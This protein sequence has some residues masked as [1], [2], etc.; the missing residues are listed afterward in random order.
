MAGVRDKDL[1]KQRGFP[2]GVDNVSPDQALPRDDDGNS[3]AARKLVN[4]D[5]VDDK[6]RTRPGRVLLEEG[7]WHSP[8]R[9][10]GKRPARAMFAVK[11][12]DLR[13]VEN[14]VATTTIRAGVGTRRISYTEVLGDLWWS[15]G[16]IIRRIRR[17]DLADMPIGPG[18]P[19][20]P[21]AEAYPGGALEAG[22]YAIAATWFDADGRESGAWGSVPVE[23]PAGHS[24]RVFDI[25]AAPETAVLC[26]IYA[27]NTNGDELYAAKEVAAGTTNTL[28]TAHDVREATRALETLWHDPFPPCDTL[29]WWNGR[30]FGVTGKNCLVWSPALRP[31][32]HHPDAYLRQGAEITL[33][34]PLQNAG[35]WFADHKNTY[36]LQGTDPKKD[37]R[38]LTKYDEPAL[39]GASIVVPG[40]AVGVDTTELVAVWLSI[41]KRTNGA[42][43]SVGMPDG[44]LIRL[45]EGKLGMPTGDDGAILLREHDGLR[46]LVATYLTH[47]ANRMA[48]GDRASASVTR[49][50]PV[51]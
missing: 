30:L 29:K 12:G 18:C 6:P 22:T 41:D 50:D 21:N 27:T 7:N 16:R 46:Q 37:W 5:L 1:V 20:A 25:P 47:G 40:K 13:Q 36:W 9:F 14:G 43:F 23:V 42:T 8:G 32:L 3:I 35:A 17:T 38:R 10:P 26:R 39:K 45:Q 48:I 11:D 31:Q 33:F 49:Y 4:V 15:N 34:E 44:T 24:I 51:S 19:G 2:A 28:I